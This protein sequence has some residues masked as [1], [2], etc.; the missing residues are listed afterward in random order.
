MDTGLAPETNC[1]AI[2]IG[3]TGLGG[4]AALVATGTAVIV[5]R[6]RGP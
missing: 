6:M 2:A 3:R 4:V 5:L 1:Q